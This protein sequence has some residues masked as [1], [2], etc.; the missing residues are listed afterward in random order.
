MRPVEEREK[1][2]RERTVERGQWPGRSCVGS[3]SLDPLRHSVT[4]LYRR[5]PLRE[6]TR[7]QVNDVNRAISVL[8][9]D[10]PQP[11]E[12][13]GGCHEYSLEVLRE[14]FDPPLFRRAALSF[15]Q[16]AISEVGCNGITDEA[17]LVVLIDRLARFQEGNFACDEN[18]DALHALQYAL[19]QLQARTRDRQRRGV[20]GEHKP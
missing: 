10:E 13:G 17:L 4:A 2:L 6:L 8:V 3:E 14:D 15:Q 5:E 19:A 11:P 9:L 16:G 12:R 7:H 1:L 20:E 18:A